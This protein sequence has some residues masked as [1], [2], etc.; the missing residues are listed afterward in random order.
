M[1]ADLADVLRKQIDVEVIGFVD[2]DT[3]TH[4]LLICGFP[5]LGSLDEIP[6]LV[7]GYGVS[8][9]IICTR[10]K[11]VLERVRNF[12]KELPIKVNFAFHGYTVVERRDA[13]LISLSNTQV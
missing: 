11:G 6:K 13:S 3:E 4:H 8:E 12:A 5:V 9:V 7:R 1:G 2:D 10:N